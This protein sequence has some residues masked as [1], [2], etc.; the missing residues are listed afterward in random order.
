M[1]S[2]QCA[3]A[4]VPGRCRS[5]MRRGRGRWYEMVGM[6]C[7]CFVVCGLTRQGVEGGVEEEVWT[8]DCASGVD[9]GGGIK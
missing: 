5:T 6:G 9:G 1:Q 4:G 7:L 2:A 8:V 3:G